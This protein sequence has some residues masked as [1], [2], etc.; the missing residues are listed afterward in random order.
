M[1]TSYN[2]VAGQSVE[3]LAALSDG[4]F[5]V[6]MTLLLLEL[7][8][9]VREPGMTEG[10]LRHALVLLAPQLLVYLMSFLTLGI[11]WV[12]Q[13]T[14]LNHLE[15]SERHLTWIHLAFLFLVTL[16]PFST[17]L[18]TEFIT[19]RT[20]LIA[21]WANILLL[22]AMLYLSWGRATRAGLLKSDTPP[23]VVDA[24][25][26]RIWTAQAFYAFGA[27]LCV[28][29]PYWSI[30]FIVF[31]QLYYAIAPRYERTQRSEVA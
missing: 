15:R 22:G 19:Y 28:F 23:R 2:Q 17:R 26:R 13:Q 10:T 24:I 16:M 9:P 18:L 20:A 11:F 29:H 14:Q 31:M 8:V 27:L 12:G 5:G 30:G 21:Y 3:R 7:H 4:S 6:A 1:D 25:C